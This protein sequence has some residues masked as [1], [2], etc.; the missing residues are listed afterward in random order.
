VM[1]V[2]K[3]AIDDIGARQ[4]GRQRDLGDHSWAFTHIAGKA[5][6]IV[7]LPGQFVAASIP[8]VYLQRPAKRRTHILPIR[9]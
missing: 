8:A 4:S 6:R 3:C 2:S 5:L 7:H 9:S 1:P